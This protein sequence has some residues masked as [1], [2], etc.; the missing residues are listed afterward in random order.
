MRLRPFQPDDLPKLYEVDQACFAPGIAYSKRELSAFI[1]N[2]NSETWI[3]EE[4]GEIAGFLIAEREPRKVLHLITIDVVATFRRRG[5]GSLLMDAAESW[6]REQDLKLIG[7]ETAVDNLA[8]Q[9]FYSERGY[10]KVG[11]IEG[12]YGDGTSAWVMVKELD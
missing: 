4:N 11:E 10:R 5:V 8:A 12:Y 9:T 3:A 6:A 7:L 1:R 2:R